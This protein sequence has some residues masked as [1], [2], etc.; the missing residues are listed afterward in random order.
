GNFFEVCTRCHIWPQADDRHAFG[1]LSWHL[2]QHHGDCGLAAWSV[3]VEAEGRGE[4]GADANAATEQGQ[5]REVFADRL[6]RQLR[7]R[8]RGSVAFVTGV[9][10]LVQVTRVG[11]HITEMI[12]SLFPRN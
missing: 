8:S 11:S 2:C 12:Y 4:V 6:R 5:G 10:S 1:D 3:R 7:A 9:S